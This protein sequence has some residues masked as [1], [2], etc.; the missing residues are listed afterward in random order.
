MT[1]WITQLSTNAANTKVRD[2]HKRA[3]RT[4]SAIWT[5]MFGAANG[6]FPPCLHEFRERPFAISQIKLSL[7]AMQLPQINLSRDSYRSSLY[8]GRRETRMTRFEVLQ[9]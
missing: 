2:I 3:L 5:F 8:F 7:V 9:E 6:C 4:F 1:P